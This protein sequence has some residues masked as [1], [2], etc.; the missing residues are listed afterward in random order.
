MARKR[1]ILIIDARF[2]DDISDALIAGAENAIEAA[3]FTS[4]CVQV[5][6]A[7]EIP[8]AI[9]LGE[10]SGK[11]CAYVALGCV[12]RG[13]TYHFEIV[14]GECSRGITNLAVDH[15]VLIGN[16]VLTVE[17]RDQAWERANVD[18][19]DGGKGAGAANA[20]IA[21]LNLREGF[22]GR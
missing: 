4:E 10:G 1:H 20:A 12:I 15:G 14:A 3:G 5:P 13:E 9:R 22:L 11:F 19:K 17:N 7:L 8:A 6:G 18:Q 2:Y 16:G 21:L